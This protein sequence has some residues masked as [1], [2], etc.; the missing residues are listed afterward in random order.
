MGLPL[1]ERA[2]DD[3]V[4]FALT[5]RSGGGL[6]LTS[7][8]TVDPSR[9]P[10]RAPGTGEQYRFHFDMGQCIGCQC[11]VVACNEQNGNP[12]SINW[13]RVSEIEG[14]WFPNAT[15]SFLSM[16]C[17]HCA[18]PTC[19]A[20]CPVDAYTKDPLTGIVNHSAD[21]CIGCQYCTWNCS[22]GVPQYNAE[23]GVVGKCD[24]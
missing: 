23:L 19:L 9:I 12:A 21:Q 14:G 24:M 7:A 3:D 22:Y 6:P 18:E 20:G 11:C 1:L 5:R 4:A 10:D 2:A 17:N 13:R 15:R 16:G 8:R